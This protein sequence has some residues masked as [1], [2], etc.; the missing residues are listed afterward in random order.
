MAEVKGIS[1]TRSMY[2]VSTMEE[3]VFEWDSYNIGHI[4]RHKVSPS[5]AEQVIGN[6]PIF[7]MARQKS[8]TAKS[9]GR[10][11]GKPIGSAI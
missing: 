9:G 5:E 3:G 2:N 4:K 6:D 11:T 10:F 1:I 8:P 7:R